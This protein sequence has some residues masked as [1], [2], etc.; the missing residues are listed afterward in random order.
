MVI[1]TMGENLTSPMINT[2]VSK[3]ATK[4]KMARYMGFIGMINST[5]RALGPSIGST[6]LYIFSYNGLK[7][8]SAVD[9]FGLG[10]IVIFM[11]FSGMVFRNSKLKEKGI[12][13]R[14]VDPA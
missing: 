1:I 2:V 14:K 3:I 12:I 6:F 9:I 4:G 10:S 13:N 7:V 11:V 8:W 5:G